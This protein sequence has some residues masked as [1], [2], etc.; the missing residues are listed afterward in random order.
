MVPVPAF[1]IDEP[2]SVTAGALAANVMLLLLVV[3]LPA[4][5]T[6]ASW[7]KLTVPVPLLLRL[8]SIL[9]LILAVTLA[10]P[11]PLKLKDPLLPLATVSGLCILIEL[12]PDRTEK[13]VGDENL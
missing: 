5:F 9:P 13:V 6:A 2:V 12:P 11:P 4:R 8:V 3:I 7:E 1:R 10:F